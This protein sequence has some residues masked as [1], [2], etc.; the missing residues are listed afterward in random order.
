MY[1]AAVC[2]KFQVT[3]STESKDRAFQIPMLSHTKLSYFA[4]VPNE[5]N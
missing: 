2:A 3:S 4:S 1:T 5:M